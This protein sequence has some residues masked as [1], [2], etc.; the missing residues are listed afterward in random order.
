MT[1]AADDFVST[2]LSQLKVGAELRQPIYDAQSQ[3]RPLLLAAGCTLTE[4]Q[5][6]ALQR[7]GV[8][9]VLVHR[10]E[11]ERITGQVSTST[12]IAPR[13][14]PSTPATPLPARRSTSAPP[15][16]RDDADSFHRSVPR[17]NIL[18]RDPA[19]AV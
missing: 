13:P 15:G 12:G 4:S 19:R 10:S 6:R 9:S 14:I 17:P 1:V 18:R 3:R 11:F 7:R 8:T 2:R 5:L 16:W